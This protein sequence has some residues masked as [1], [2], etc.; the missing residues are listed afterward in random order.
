[1]WAAC[2]LKLQLQLRVVV[3]DSSAKKKAADR[4]SRRRTSEGK[5]ED[6]FSVKYDLLSLKVVL[7]VAH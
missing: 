7:C 4:Q 3:G 5:P 6:I 2:A 1:M